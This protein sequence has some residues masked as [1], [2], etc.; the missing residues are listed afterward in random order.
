MNLEEGIA[1]YVQRKRAAGL[2]FTTANRTYRAFLRLVGDLSLSHISVHHVLQFLDCPD[3]SIVAFRRRHSLLQHFFQYWVAHG[4]MATLP[5]PQNRP[6]LRSHFLPYIYTRDEV[7][8]LLQSARASRSTND[9]INHRTS[10]AAVLTLY[11]TG[12]TV[13]E[14]TR[15]R[16]EDVDL[17]NGC[18]TF[19]GS[20]LKVSRCIPIGNDLVRAMRQYVGWQSRTRTH[21]EFFYSRIDGKEI[22]PRALRVYFERF[23]RTAGIPGYRESSQSPCLRDLR[24]TFAVHQIT[25]WIRKKEDL[26][27]MLPALGT[28]LGNAGLESTERYLLLTPERF[29]S[30][31]N[32][33]SPQKA[34][35][36]W[37]DDPAVLQFL[38]SL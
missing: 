18:I 24:A 12:A 8:K 20:R 3:T 17:Q 27:R 22:T 32:M 21:N 16:N 35:T 5:M 13:G 30:A 29:Q 33:L 7:R 37:R 34:Y 10:R 11:A 23:R 15:L 38:A 9:K 6:P 19:S 31:L 36:R 28:Y 26:N 4:A 25:A 1:L 14:V 2:S